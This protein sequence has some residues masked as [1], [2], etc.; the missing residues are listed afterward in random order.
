[1]NRRLLIAGLAA[2]IAA[3]AGL[4]GGALAGGSGAQDAPTAG[5]GDAAQVLLQGFSAGDTAA[6]IARLEQRVGAAPEDSEGLVLLGLAYQQRARETGDPSFYPRSEEA[7]DR[8]LELAPDNDLALTGLAALAAT[9][10]R[11]E[12]SRRLARR[13]LDLNPYSAEALGVLGDALVELG[14]YEAAFATFDRMA[15]TKPGLPSYARIA[16][17]RELKGKTDS[18]AEAMAL[19]ARSAPASGE[20]GAWALV[21]LGNLR[22]NSGRL[23]LAERAYDEALARF[24]DY[25][26]AQA[27]LARVEAARGRTDEAV[28]LYRAALEAVPLP[29][30][31]GRLAETLAAAGRDG[32]AREA[33]ELLDVMQRLLESNGARTELETALV[34]LDRNANVEDALARVREAYA[35]RRSIEAEDVLAWALYRNGRCEEALHALRPRASPRD[36]RRAQAFPPRDDRAVPRPNGRGQGRVRARARDQP[37]LLAPLGAGRGG[38]GLVKR[39]LLVA[40]A[41]VALVWPASGGAHPLGNFTVNRYAEIL[42]SGDRVYVTY[43]L[44]LA[45]I[46]TFQEGDSR[47]LAGV[48]PSARG[49]P[50]ARD[51][52]APRAV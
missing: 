42:L 20:S 51:R 34:D 38:G 32:E 10:H 31:A 2:G 35:E 22:F 48:R 18:A 26:R 49:R 13:A 44:D 15:A 17:A 23:R 46:P 21:E 4:F 47:A 43:A 25:H 41:L 33:Y 14:R 12:E 45:E 16:Y 39:L 52:R 29:E 3:T 40:I 37:V 8:S 5:T 28:A 11:F 9:R 27:G 50:R 19:A 1:M 36:A 7:L 6:T 24:P 30:Y